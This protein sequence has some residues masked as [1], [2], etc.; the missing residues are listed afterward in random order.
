[1]AEEEEVEAD[2]K[3]GDVKEQQ[4]KVLQEE[5][6][7][8]QKT[9]SKMQKNF[10]ALEAGHSSRWFPSFVVGGSLLLFHNSHIVSTTGVIKMH[11]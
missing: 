10:R 2:A 7:T 9:Y 11:F 6:E 8:E 5:A 4:L 3:E 1:M